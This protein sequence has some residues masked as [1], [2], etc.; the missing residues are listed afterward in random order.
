MTARNGDK[1]L[2][3]VAA[4][5][6]AALHELSKAEHTVESLQHDAWQARNDISQGEGDQ[7]ISLIDQGK[8]ALEKIAKESP[9]AWKTYNAAFEK[10]SRLHDALKRDKAAYDV[11]CAGYQ[12]SPEISPL[13]DKQTPREDDSD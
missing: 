5:Y 1:K 11:E 9:A 13:P 10:A 7:D 12:P 6:E 4:E 8:E 3:K 2:K